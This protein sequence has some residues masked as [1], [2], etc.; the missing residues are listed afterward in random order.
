[1]VRNFDVLRILT[2]I[3]VILYI[4]MFCNQCF[5]KKMSKDSPSSLEFSEYISTSKYHL[6]SG[7]TFGMRSVW[8]SD[9]ESTLQ[10]HSQSSVHFVPRKR[11]DCSICGKSYQ[12]SAGLY[13][14]TQM[15]K[16]KF[17]K[18]SLCDT[19]FPYKGNLK[20]HL[21]TVHNAVQCSRCMVTYNAMEQHACWQ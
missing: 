12:T 7:N 2:P 11:F 3:N 4:K 21:S 18:C 1:M 20:R 10:D 14:H 16:G 15:H 13:L 5:E 19:R 9:A 8:T 17:Y 6:P